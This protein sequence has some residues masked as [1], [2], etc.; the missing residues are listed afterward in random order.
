MAAHIIQVSDIHEG[1]SEHRYVEILS[2]LTSNLVVIF[3]NTQTWA[4]AQA[5]ILASLICRYCPVQLRVRGM[6]FP[7]PPPLH[8]RYY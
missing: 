7:P 3:D 5:A 6:R 1:F 8:S 4:M 2:P